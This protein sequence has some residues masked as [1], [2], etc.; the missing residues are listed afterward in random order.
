MAAAERLALQR[1]QHIHLIGVGGVGMSGLAG[2]LVEHGFTVTGSDSGEGP[3]VSRLR[4]AGVKVHVPQVAGG[5]G[6]ADVVVASTAIPEENPELVDAQQRGLPI[7]HRSQLLAAIIEPME[8]IAVS[9][10]HGKTTTTSMLATILLEADRDPLVVVGGDAANIGSNYHPGAEKLAVFEA[11]ESDAT[12]LRY[13]PCSQIITNVEADH[14]DQHGTFEAVCDVFARFIDLVPEDGFLAWGADC[15]PLAEMIDRC[16]GKAIPC[17]LSETAVFRAEQIEPL[18]FGVSFR[19]L[20]EGDEVGQAQLQ[21]P[22]SHNVLNALCAIAAA[23]EVGIAPE[24][25]LAGVEAFR[26]VERRFELIC[27]LDGAL[28]VDDYAHHP[29]EVAATLDAARR[30]WPERRLVA[31][32]QPHLYSRTR[33]FMHPFASALAVADEVIVAGI[34]GA[35]EDPIEGVDAADLARRVREIAPDRGVEYIADRAEIAD[36]VR[37]MARPGDLILTIGAGDIRRVAEDLA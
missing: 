19:L 5:A 6:D 13:G 20:V 4:G 31:I 30:G 32:F 24:Q 25:A 7:Y 1:G 14:L 9:G 27:E 35:R 34:Y 21:V 36:R 10:T 15:A 26:G 3:R 12:F 8:K 23:S 18:P 22:G 28:V 37:E 33:D 11:C 17:G 29:T 16:A 2:V